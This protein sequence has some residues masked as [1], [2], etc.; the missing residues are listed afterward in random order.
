MRQTSFCWC[1][2]FPSLREQAGISSRSLPAGR[3]Y[4]WAEV[5]MRWFTARW[6][7]VGIPSCVSFSGLSLGKWY[8]S[9]FLSVPCLQEKCCSSKP[10]HLKRIWA[11][12]V[13]LVIWG[14]HPS[15]KSRTNCAFQLR[16]GQ[17]CSLPG[18]T[19]SWKVWADGA[20]GPHRGWG[21]PA[22]GS[23]A[24]ARLNAWVCTSWQV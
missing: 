11:V 22:G 4:S 12:S 13:I 5:R 19:G 14:M 9:T 18:G 1:Q 20:G 7:P 16:C 3:L 10:C 6:L 24:A 23:R 8:F 2:G 15:E 21:V 17:Q